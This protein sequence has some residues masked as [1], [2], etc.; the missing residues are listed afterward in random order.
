MELV[1]ARGVAPAAPAAATATQRAVQATHR[2]SWCLPPSYMVSARQGRRRA[3]GRRC[4]PP[5]AAAASSESSGSSNGAPNGMRRP[6][7]VQQA[8]AQLGTLDPA[9]GSADGGG[10]AAAAEPPRNWTKFVAETLLP[11]QQGKFRLRGYRHTSDGGLTYTEPSVII[12]GQPEGLE[13]VP[14]RV[15]DACFTSEV[16]GSLKCDCREQLQLAMEYIRDHPPGMVIYLQQEGRGIGLANKIAAYALQEKGLDTV[17]ANRALGLPDDC[18][19]YSAVAHILEEMGIKSIRL[20]TN[21]PRK[22]TEMAALGIPVTGRIPCLVQAQ[23]YN[24]GYLGAKHR[25]MSHILNPS[26]YSDE[27]EEEGQ[28]GS[29]LEQEPLEGQFCFFDHEGE[30]SSAGIPLEAPVPLPEGLEEA[31]SSMHSSGMHSSGSSSSSSGGSSSK[32]EPG[33]C[34][35]ASSVASAD[36]TD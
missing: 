26:L 25:R 15:H 5:V 11:T 18:R 12:A 32:R 28:A 6:T 20:M 3:A 2:A 36:T 13:D 8:A 4:V 21:N 17:D 23:K 34:G 22:I 1:A 30:P 35:S 14:V 24:A 7:L 27:E 9:G 31:G 19:E 10:G 29:D 16:L 33:G